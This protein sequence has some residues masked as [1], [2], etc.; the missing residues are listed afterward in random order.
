MTRLTLAQAVPAMAFAPVMLAK[1]VG[2]FAEEGIDLDHQMAGSAANALAALTTGEA[3]LMAGGGDTIL[4]AYEKRL[5]VL[6]FAGVTT[7]NLFSWSVSNRWLQQ[8]GVSRQ[9]PLADRLAALKGAR[10]GTVT[11]G[12][13]GPRLGNYM[14]LRSGYDPEATVDWAAVGAGP[15]LVAALRQG[16]VDA[17]FNGVP[18]PEYVED[19]GIGKVYIVMA[20]EF[21]FTQSFIHNGLAGKRQWVE[22]AGVRPGCSYDGDDV[23]EHDR[24]VPCHGSGDQRRLARR[25]D[26]LDE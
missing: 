26:V 12:G 13:L 5:D 22:E 20:E 8:T 10:V 15:P 4:N 14:L 9:S 19:E 24:G 2:L 1:D 25:G 7:A 3:Q 11:I 6:A 16:Q 23:A 18:D 21:T 17:I